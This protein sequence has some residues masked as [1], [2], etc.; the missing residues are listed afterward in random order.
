[1]SETTTTVIEKVF[2][3]NGN[4]NGR[5]WTRYDVKAGDGRKYV[6]FKD[7]VGRAAQ[8]CEGHPAELEFTVQT[9]DRGTN[10]LLDAVRG[11]LNADA[12]PKKPEGGNGYVKAQENP[13]TQRSIRASVA[14]EHAVASY[15]DFPQGATPKQVA[16]IVLPL[17]DAYMNWLAERSAAPAEKPTFTGDD[18]VPF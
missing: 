16:E 7:P 10:Y 1:M 9:N 6:T 14:L 2:T 8:G 4:K 13:D 18:D 15:T 12:V 5:E 3:A 17:A 11:P